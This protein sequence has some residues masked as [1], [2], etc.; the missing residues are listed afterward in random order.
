MDGL[1]LIDIYTLYLGRYHNQE[2]STAC[3]ITPLLLYFISLH[4]PSS[5]RLIPYVLMNAAFPADKR[6][7]NGPY[8][9]HLSGAGGASHGADT[10]RH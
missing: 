2:S 9:S 1:Y 8:V 5:R 4:K 7:R 6:G 3:K 10:G